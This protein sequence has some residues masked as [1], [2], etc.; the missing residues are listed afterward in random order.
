MIVPLS[1]IEIESLLHSQIVGRIGCSKNDVS[2]VV[3]IS[4]AYEG[5]YVYCHSY[6]GKKIDMMRKNPEVC[7]QVDETTDMSNW[8]SVIAWGEFEELVDPDE[9]IR[10]LQI[11]L[12]RR[13]PIRSSVT[14]HLGKT[15]PFTGNEHNSTNDIPGIVFRINLQR[16][17]GKCEHTSESP[18]LFFN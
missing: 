4:Y 13:L 8:K 12:K 16:K 1:S 5:G 9:R 6:E 2:Y 18:T 14:T 15:W 17:T 10:G 7:F 11:L 3:P